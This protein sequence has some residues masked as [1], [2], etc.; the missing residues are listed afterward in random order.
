MP[1]PGSP[2][3]RR[4]ELGSVLRS[5]RDNAGL[6]AEQAAEHIGCSPSKISRLENGQR[7]ADQV[8]ILLL[9]D[10]YQVDGEHRWRLSNLAAEGKRGAGRPHHSLDHSDYIG[11]E[12]ETTSIS[13]YGLA[14]VPGLLQTPEYARAIVSAGV[15]TRE[16]R[17]IDERV[18]VRIARQQLLSSHDGPGFEAVL[19]ESVLHRVVASPAVMLAQLRQLL[20]MSQL[21]NV[22]IRVV[23]YAAGNV[24]AGVNKFIIMRFGL[25]GI[26]DV[27][28][29]E[30]LTSHRY[31][32][33]SQE[34]EIYSATFRTL[35]AL[36]ADPATTRVMFA[37]K[38]RTYESLVR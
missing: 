6:T 24:P 38:I 19:D 4:H 36:S 18:R 2:L 37:A 31:L 26:A 3:A 7:G 13:D 30:E 33:K 25:S 1:A 35:A 32:R 5:L 20:E 27:V 23:P 29:I 14:I 8:D 34:V 17:I 22:T 10:L 28:L 9:C 16:S 12:A 21:P 11:L 15:P